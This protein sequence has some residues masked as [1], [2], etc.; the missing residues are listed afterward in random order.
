MQKV[1]VGMIVA[2]FGLLA[3][4]A[5]AGAQPRGAV[6]GKN[7]KAPAPPVGPALRPLYWQ[8][9]GEPGSGG[10]ITGFRISPHDGKRMLIGGDMLGIG[11]SIDGGKTWQAT[12][13]L[14]SYE[15]GDFTWHPKSQK[16][17]WAGTVSGPYVSHDG[18]KNWTEKRKGLPP[19]SGGSYSAPIERV[20]IDP[21]APEHLLAIGGSSRRWFSPGDPAWGAIWKSDD[22]GDSWTRLTT[23]TKDGASGA[24]D[25][26]GIN[27]VSAE[28]AAG[29]SQ[30][31]LA[32]LDGNGVW[33][34]ADGGKTWTKANAG[35]PHENIERVIAHPKD[36]NIFWA[37]LGNAKLP[38]D[39]ECTP[40]GIY[41]TVDGGKTWFGI[42]NGLSQARSDNDNFTARYKAFGVSESNPDVMYAG[43]GAWNT[44]DLYATKDG[45]KSW[46]LV[47]TKQNVGNDNGDA[48]RAK[49]VQVRTA[50]FAG[51]AG[52]TISVDPNNP[53]IAYNLGTEHITATYDGGKTWSDA[54]NDPVG[55][56]AWRGR[57]Y[58]GLCC[59]N[60]VFNPNKPGEAILT[61]MD[62]GKLWMSR[63]NLKSWTYHGN[64]PWPW[65]GGVDAAYAGNSI[66]AT[67]GQFGQFLGILRSTD[68]GATWQ[69]LGGAKRGLP[70]LQSGNAQPAAIYALPD[71]PKRVWAI[72]AGKLYHSADGGE[73]WKVTLEKPGLDWIAGDPKKSGHFYISAEKSIY[74]TKDSGATFAPIGGPKPATRISADAKG[75][76]YAT[77]W[78]AERGGVWR[79]EAGKW[80]RL[81]NDVYIH[82]IA[83]DPN[84]PMRLAVATHDHPY[85]DVPNATGVWLSADDGKTW[86]PANDGLP[87]LRGESVT[88]DPHTPGRLIFGTH[89]RGFW[90]MT[91][92]KGVV[93]NAAG[94]S[95]AMTEDDA[96]AAAIDDPLPLPAP[97]PLAISNGSMD[98]GGDLPQNWDGKW[99]G[100]GKIKVARDPQIF[101][102][103]PASLRV[104]SVDG[105]A[106][107]QASQ[108]RDA[109]A[110]A[111]FTIRGWVKSQGS[112]KV[113]VAIQPYDDAWHPITFLQAG[114][115]QNDTDWTRFEKTITLP[116]KT[117][118][119][120]IN[121]LLEGA[122]KAWLDEVEIK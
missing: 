80:T 81:W 54:G 59:T 101:K 24:A 16:T 99:V 82:D 46:A 100:E 103:G 107:G 117:A 89:G 21:N 20:L 30:T 44:G 27:I 109:P 108:M 113:N 40:G 106:K 35:L 47:A 60:A 63:D 23:L 115:V 18:G 114:Y 12:F 76:L 28:F 41:K 52:G 75:R 58:S 14:R 84:D 11:L 105:N 86:S 42:N 53:N 5:P 34:S 33:K 96:K 49:A 56:T 8:P 116:E 9:L 88:F 45:G 62:A 119:F 61:G 74:E 1:V 85:H 110:G 78:R 50:Y 3:S 90:M 22:A 72:I 25:A 15:I 104:E 43:D 77:S 10:A 120:G 26:K 65:G 2:L 13:G 66:Y 36:P 70:E 122:G 79:Y 31:I 39:K 68:D 4:S 92:P 29:S 57:G 38:G 95:Y 97:Q 121:L 87:M 73:N 111:T 91:W 94:K 83:P 19:I 48:K 118:H 55:A 93:P 32:G 17:V 112:V 98:E 102:K 64:E 6:K 67:A 7:I 37:A 69:V 51:L 71:N